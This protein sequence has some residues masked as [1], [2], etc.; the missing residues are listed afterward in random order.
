[1][2]IL[3][4]GLTMAL[5]TAVAPAFAQEFRPAIDGIGEAYAP[6][7][8]TGAGAPEG[9]DFGSGVVASR[10]GRVTIESGAPSLPG[11]RVLRRRVWTIPR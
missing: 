8:E 6:A 4:A 10:R 9:A 5:L 11:G 3:V 7:S 1:V 2:R